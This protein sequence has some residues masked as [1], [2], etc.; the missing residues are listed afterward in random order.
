MGGSSEYFVP[1]AVVLQA[2]QHRQAAQQLA[3]GVFSRLLRGPGGLW[4]GHVAAGTLGVPPH[5]GGQGFQ[6]GLVRPAVVLHRFPLEHVAGAGP[7]QHLC[8]P[9]A[10]AGFLPHGDLHGGAVRGPLRAGGHRRWADPGGA[11]VEDEHLRPALGHGDRLLLWPVPSL[12]GVPF[13][14]P[15]EHHLGV[16]GSDRWSGNRPADQGAG[17]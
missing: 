15:T 11:A 17:V 2:G 7:G 12:Q 14:L 13:H 8:V 4:P 16:P 9:A 1:G 5:A 3:D 6:Q 10:Q